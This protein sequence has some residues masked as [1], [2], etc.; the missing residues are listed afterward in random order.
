MVVLGSKAESL[1]GDSS[2]RGLRRAAEMKEKTHL[3]P[4]VLSLPSVQFLSAARHGI[5]QPNMM[6]H[7]N[8]LL[9]LSG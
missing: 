8:S 7:A 3:I 4:H 6:G 1:D 2:Q 9:V 5:L